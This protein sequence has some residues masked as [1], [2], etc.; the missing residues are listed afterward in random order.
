MANV[1]TKRTM[2]ANATHL[3]LSAA[4]A[5][6]TIDVE[7]GLMDTLCAMYELREPG[8]IQA[9][10]DRHPEIV[11]VLIEAAWRIPESLPSDE[12]VALDL[13]Q[14]PDDD[15]DGNGELFAIVRTRLGAE[16]IRPSLTRMQEGWLIDAGRRAGGH[17][18]V[19]VEFV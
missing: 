1:G 2:P 16:E 18:N 4:P 8:A 13:V 15:D 11:D 7:P 10:V 5:S 12:R 14:V 9:F 3:S 19:H 6:A 17:F